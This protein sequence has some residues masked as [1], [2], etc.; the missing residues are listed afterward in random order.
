MSNQ[1][2]NPLLVILIALVCA[3]CAATSQRLGITRSAGGTISKAGQTAPASPAPTKAT[4]LRPEAPTVEP[5]VQRGTGRVLGDAGSPVSPIGPAGGDITLNFD[6]TPVADVVAI[7]LGDYL[8]LPFTIDPSV[9]GEVTFSSTEGLSK[10]D[11]LPVLETLL[12]SKD[13][14]LVAENEGY[15]IVP[16]EQARSLSS[17][18]VIG[19]EA[20][21][22]SGYRSLVIPLSYVSAADMAEIV[23]SYGVQPV[24]NRDRNA[25]IVSG[26]AAQIR[27]VQQ[28]V[29]TFDV[30]WL[31]GMS[32]ALHP[33]R[34][35]DAADVERELDA[36]F[37]TGGEEQEGAARVASIDRLNALLVVAPNPGLLEQYG[38]WIKRL[39]RVS[40]AGGRAL[41]VYHVQN[42]RAQD[43]A[44]V[45]TDVFLPGFLDDT[46]QEGVYGGGGRSTIVEEKAMN[47]PLEEEGVDDVSAGSRVRVIADKTNNALLILA[48]ERDY[49]IIEGAL[50]QL[51][52]EPM[53]VLIEASIIEIMLTDDLRYG[54]EWLI[55]GRSEDYTGDAIL[56]FGFPGLGQITPG[57]SYVLRKADEV[58][59]AINALAED[60]QINVLSSPA[61]M[62]LNNQTATIRVG[63]EV[64][65]PTRQSTSNIS[66]DAPT[67][68]EIEYRNTGVLLAVTPRLNA[69]GLVTIDLD[70]EV[71]NVTETTTSDIDAPTF[72][73]RQISSSIAINSGETVV[74][75]GLIREQQSN[76][77]SGIPVLHK[78]PG[79]GKLFGTTARTTQRTELVVLITPRAVYEPKDLRAVTEEYQ[80]KMM[81]LAPA[82][83]EQ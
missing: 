6:A 72:L 67:V 11:L 64:P 76:N 13:A 56:D 69:N 16:M 2:R 23:S 59:L 32:I 43:L 3:S 79:I 21:S 58:R 48:D 34:Y 25:V 60:A 77:D 8:G 33:L 5:F 22:G 20:V 41:Y 27:Q 47:T 73:Q 57:F 50:R 12:A 54:L 24:V 68:N 70:Q 74:L 51:D 7:M 75:G 55:R 82:I 61:L 52:V 62:V 28:L 39:D 49:A 19:N 17:T 42:G 66:P 71:S 15:R 40:V 35:A 9:Q 30:D 83:S 81:G 78:I 31:K 80:R 10:E 36:V 65:I 45:L 18:G 29:R 26:T 38:Q 53:Q 37:G 4:P 14:A 44:R 46:N 63:D 1:L